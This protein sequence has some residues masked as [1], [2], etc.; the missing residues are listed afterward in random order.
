M[1]DNYNDF[2]ENENLQE[3]SNSY[4]YVSENSASPKKPKKHTGLKAVAFLLCLAIVGGGSVQVYKYIDKN[5]PKV[6][7]FSDEKS[8]TESKEER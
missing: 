4:S 2:N 5:S 3:S 8:D 7:E 6:S 1:S